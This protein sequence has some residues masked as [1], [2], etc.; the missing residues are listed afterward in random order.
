MTD[1]LI[2]ADT[3]RSPAMRHEIPL[4][5]PDPFLYVE[6]DGRRAV[7]VTS[8]ELDR[9]AAAAPGVET[10]P[11]E[12]FGIDEL[13]RGGTRP[14]DAWLEVYTRALR[15]IGV[16]EA[17]VPRDFPLE[18]ADHFRA[19]GISISV[20]RELFDGRR[21]RKIATEIAG[22]RRAQRACEAALDRAREM[23]RGASVADGGAL[24]LEGEPLTCE[25]IK[26]EMELIFISHGTVADEFIVA[27][28]AQA[29]VG[30]DMG[31]GPI[32]AGE[33]IVFDLWP[34][35]R[36]TAVYTD[37]TR[38]YVVGDVPDELRE[39]HRLCKEALERTAAAAGPG[40]NGRD[41]MQ[42]TCDL[43][44]EHGYPTQLTKQPGE[45]LDS[46]FFHGLGH[47]VGL[48]VHERPRLSVVG[49][50][51]VPGDVITLE[52]GLYRAGWG[53]VRLEDI[54]VVTEDGAETV[55]QYPYEL[56]P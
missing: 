54:L 26:A 28:G 34:R 56:E 50:D 14:D 49:D 39:Y 33:S 15:E 52:P 55:T 7:V 43:F 27:H 29:A 41:L 44:A 31:S 47:G 24:L 4:P 51:L 45:V 5:V 35:D 32:S 40:V 2:H 48:E 3:T 38:T 17:A 8:F 18:L 23:L 9:I 1:V 10:L 13:L 20:D 22:L 6:H 21:R 36:E 11:P 42:M 12:R 19:Q 25:R 37:M 16:T 30:H 46:G 53:G